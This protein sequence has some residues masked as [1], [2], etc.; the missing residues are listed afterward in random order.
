MSTLELTLLKDPEHC[1]RCGADSD[2]MRIGTMQVDT[3]IA[4]QNVECSSCGLEWT[5]QYKFIGVEIK[6][7][8]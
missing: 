3:H 1:P 7:D 6:E 5:D 8:L 4:W 2:A